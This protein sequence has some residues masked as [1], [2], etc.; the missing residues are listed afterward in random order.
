MMSFQSLTAIV[1][2]LCV[3]AA[4]LAAM[5][6][7]ALRD[8]GE[9]LPIAGLGVIGLRNTQGATPMN[10]AIAMAGQSTHFSRVSRSCMPSFL[11]LVTAP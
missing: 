6:A 11:G 4:G 2:I 9:R 8:R 7:E 1:P 10:T 5:L 3:V